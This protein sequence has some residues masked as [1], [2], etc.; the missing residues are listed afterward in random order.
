M[1]AMYT[2]LLYCEGVMKVIQEKC[3]KC[4]ECTKVCPVQAIAEKDGKVE[5]DKSIC[6]SCGCCAAVCPNKAIEFE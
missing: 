5:I 4:L 6:L 2:L 3:E 1:F